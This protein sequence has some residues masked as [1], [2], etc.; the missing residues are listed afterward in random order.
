MEN[1][2]NNRI[3][4]PIGEL[5]ATISEKGIERLDFNQI[6]KLESFSL[7]ENEIFSNL[8]KQL[9]EYFSGQRKAFHLPIHLKGTE[10]QLRV[11]N[12]LMEIPYGKTISY[13]MQSLELQNHKAIRAIATANAKNPI[14]VIVPCHRVIGSDGRLSGYAGGIQAKEWL[15]NLEQNQTRLF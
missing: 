4:T 6:H 5:F 8:K 14:M 15:L 3:Q 13:K 11:W 9:S 1:H 10:F 12:Q 7:I 2:K